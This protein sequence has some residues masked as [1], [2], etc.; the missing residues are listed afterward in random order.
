MNTEYSKYLWEMMKTKDHLTTFL[1]AENRV[2]VV[3]G[4]G[5]HTIKRI[6][7]ELP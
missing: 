3:E 1:K 2:L 6:L 4:T 5:W 7:K